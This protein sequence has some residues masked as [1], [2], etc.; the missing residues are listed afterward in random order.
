MWQNATAKL[1]AIA[2]PTTDVDPALLRYT[3]WWK[4]NTENAMKEKRKLY[5]IWDKEP[6]DKVR[7][8]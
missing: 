6:T 5:I 1:L 3:W 7:K 8:A 2:A 4:E